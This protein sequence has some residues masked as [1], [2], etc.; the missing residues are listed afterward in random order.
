[1]GNSEL[2]TGEKVGLAALAVGAL[3]LALKNQEVTEPTVRA[4]NDAPPGNAGKFAVGDYIT[5]RGFFQK[6][7]ARITDTNGKTYRVRITWAD[8]STQFYKGES[9][10]FF[11]DEFK[12][13]GN[14]CAKA[15]FQGYK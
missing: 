4:Q 2:T 9:I 5:N 6:W 3:W 15:I 8:S 1:M 7:I 14:V 12:E 13:L 10:E 11:D